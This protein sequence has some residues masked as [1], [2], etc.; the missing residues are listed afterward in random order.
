MSF[1]NACMHYAHYTR[2]SAYIAA[3]IILRQLEAH[4]TR[5][6]QKEIAAYLNRGNSDHPCI[7]Y[8]PNDLLH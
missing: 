3:M 4:Y 6:L 1:V 8:G 2:A 5:E 7:D